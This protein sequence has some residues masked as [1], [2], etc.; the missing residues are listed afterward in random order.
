MSKRDAVAQILERI[1]EDKLDHPCDLDVAL[2][3]I[4]CTLDLEG[5]GEPKPV[6]QGVMMMR[7]KT[8]TPEELAARNALYNLSNEHAIYDYQLPA[9]VRGFLAAHSMSASYSMA[10]EEAGFMPKLYARWNGIPVRVV[11]VSRMGDVGISKLDEQ[12]GYFERLSI[13]ELT[14]YAVT[15]PPDTLPVSRAREFAIKAHGTQKY[16]KP[17]KDKP[18]AYHLDKVDRVLIG[19]GYVAPLFRQCAW[20]HDVV[21]DTG[22]N[23]AEIRSTFGR[24][25]GEIVWAC[26][27]FGVNRKARNADIKIKCG[28]DPEACVVKSA[29]RIANVEDAATEGLVGLSQM[30][31]K[32]AA[33][34]E[35]LVTPH[36]ND[37]MKA[38]LVAAH[39]AA[40]ALAYQSAQA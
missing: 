37:L 17:P 40:A 21:E 19:C 34:F 12:H 23:I 35:A 18:Y 16:G 5:D 24:R 14:D 20:L 6:S 9:F 15:M 29:D 11:M 4:F 38:R 28:A 30:Y 10:M 7:S 39:T 22:T 31:V 26:S 1:A 3:A 2:D 8:E 13:Y 36:I 33:D 32:E 25:V 27:G